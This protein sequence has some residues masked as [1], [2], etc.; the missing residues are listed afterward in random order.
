MKSEG[1]DKEENGREQELTGEKL[2][3]RIQVENLCSLWDLL[4]DSWS[5]Q[6]FVSSYYVLTVSLHWI[7]KMKYSCY[8]D[9]FV[10]LGWVV[11]W[12]WL[13]NAPLD[14]KKSEIIV[15]NTKLLLASL[16]RFAGSVRRLKSLKWLWPYLMGFRAASRPGKLSTY[17]V[18]DFF[19]LVSWSRAL[20]MP[21]F[22]AH[23]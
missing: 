1:K 16:L 11:Y 4:T 19:F 3:K 10:I 18:F 22:Y 12:F 8:Q 15:F 9:S 5:R 13:R 23:L 7:Y 21:S 14:K 6:S 20:F 2:A 17:I